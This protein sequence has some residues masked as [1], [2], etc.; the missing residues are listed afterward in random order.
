MAALCDVNESKII[1]T[2][3]CDVFDLQPVNLIRCRLR[4]IRQQDD[5]RHL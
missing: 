5:G 3:D 1:A 4:V 2:R